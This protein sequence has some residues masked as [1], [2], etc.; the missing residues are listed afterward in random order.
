MFLYLIASPSIAQALK[1]LL[2]SP[3]AQSG[4]FSSSRVAIADHHQTFTH[5]SLWIVRRF[6]FWKH[7][8]DLRN[9]QWLEQV[10]NHI[11]TE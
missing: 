11:P 7:P 10:L 6:F 1:H 5:F 4:G 9:F 3:K 8:L 2:C